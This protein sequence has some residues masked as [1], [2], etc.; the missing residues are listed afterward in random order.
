MPETKAK[1]RPPIG[2]RVMWVYGRKD[3]VEYG[4]IGTVTA[5]DEDSASRFTVTTDDDQPFHRVAFGA[6]SKR[7]G[8]ARVLRG[9]TVVDCPPLV[10]VYRQNA[11]RL[12]NVARDWDAAA[13]LVVEEAV[14]ARP[15]ADV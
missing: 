9:M 14:A 3:Y 4:E 10:A 5:H 12:R 8:H 6:K 11:R 15:S 2:T 13:R 7:T 1:R